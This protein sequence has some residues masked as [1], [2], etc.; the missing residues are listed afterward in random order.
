MNDVIHM[1]DIIHMNDNTSCNYLKRKKRTF[2]FF[3]I[4]NKAISYILCNYFKFMPIEIT[5]IINSYSKCNIYNNNL[6]SYL[7]SYIKKNINNFQPPELCILC[8][9]YANF[10]KRENK[11]F[12]MI[13][14]VLMEKNNINKL[15]DGNV[16][17]L[18]HAYGKLLIKDEE[19]I[20][21]LLINKKHVIQYLDSRN[22]T[23]FY[24]S[25]IKLNIHIPI[26][27]Y[28]IFKYYIKKKLSTFTDLGLTSILYSS[29]TMYPPYYFDIHFISRILF[30]L[31]K[32]KANSKSFCHQ[33]HVSLFVIHSLYNFDTF[34]L[35]FLSCIYQLLN[36]VYD[37]IN[38]QNYYDIHKSNIQKRIYPF[39]PKYNIQIQS[40][41]NIGP[42]I[43]DF[44]LLN[45][46]HHAQYMHT[47][48]SF[49]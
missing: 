37:H 27:I 34:S 31:N 41:V 18:L 24:V 25:L 23:L 8:N 6:F 13:R 47:H 7:Y 15:E 35:P 21:Y 26:Y 14:N 46:N 16:A 11:I 38:K 39:L 10:N 30:L 2:P 22:L 36:V 45:K 33:I 43:V 17:M 12:D 49:K 19:F 1:N 40:E 3:D 44:L 42:F 4:F 29:S 32:R 5:M 48:K 20:L 9:A 28:N